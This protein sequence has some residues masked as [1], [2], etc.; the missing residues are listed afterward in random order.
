MLGSGTSIHGRSLTTLYRK[1][2]EAWEQQVLSLLALLVQKYLIYWYKRKASE[3]WEQQVLSLL[4]VLVQ[5]Y[6]Y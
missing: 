1:T 3:A 5:Q 6:K 2:S 4:A